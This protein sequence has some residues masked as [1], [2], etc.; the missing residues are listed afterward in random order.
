MENLKKGARG[1]TKMYYNG[2]IPKTLLKKNDM[3]VDKDKLS[4]AKSIWLQKHGVNLLQ[5]DKTSEE[6]SIKLFRYIDFQNSGH[7]SK[8]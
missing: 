5:L 1:V 6:E 2:G 4:Y 3:Q 7:I 8:P